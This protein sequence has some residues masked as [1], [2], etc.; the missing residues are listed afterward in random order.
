MIDY[1]SS[2]VVYLR[3][4]IVPVKKKLTCKRSVLRKR[5]SILSPWGKRTTILT[6]SGLL[7]SGST[8]R[9]DETSSLFWAIFYKKLKQLLMKHFLRV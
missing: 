5:L 9:D 1:S 8:G 7:L 6:A 3:F 4:S 2:F